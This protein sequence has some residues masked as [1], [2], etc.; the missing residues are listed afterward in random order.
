MKDTGPQ[1]RKHH[2]GIYKWR[3]DEE[4]LQLLASYR[5]A[6]LESGV[7]ASTVRTECDYLRG[8]VFSS[9]MLGGPATLKGLRDDPASIAMV[10]REAPRKRGT[11]RCMLRAMFGLID[12]SVD[13]PAE[14]KRLQDEV[15]IRLIPRP[16]G[17]G[18]W[19]SSPV[20]SVARITWTGE[21]LFCH[22]T[23]SSG[24]LKQRR[25]QVHPRRRLAGTRRWRRC[26]ASPR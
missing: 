8:M 11:L 9:K 13:T 21:G 16:G 20:L 23:N 1:P 2:G 17:R 4:S 3:P 14:A 10:L 19:T 24:L 12:V 5:E 6:R 18:A 25:W 7:L 26:F 22:P 15:T